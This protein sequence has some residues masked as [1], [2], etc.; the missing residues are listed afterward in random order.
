MV[1]IA[2][3]GADDSGRRLWEAVTACGDVEVL[4]FVDPD[5]RRQGRQLLG[6]NVRPLEWLSRGCCDAVVLPDREAALSASVL[7]SLG[8]TGQ[9]VVCL[10]V[11]VNDDQLARAAADRFPDPLSTLLARPAAPGVRVG[12]FGTGAA[13]VKVWEALAGIDGADAAWFADNDVRRQGVPFLWLE[14]IAPSEIPAR[15]FD[16]VA[17]GSMSRDAIESQL[18]ALGVP[19]PRIL[20]PD[21]TADVDRIREQLAGA[22]SERWLPGARA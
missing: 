8:L 19:Q 22:L 9:R 17:I 5:P 12:V 2:I 11:T 15:S 6:V 21:V 16:V 7:A 1:R 10:P 20:A 18:I 13:G 4:A 14:V 3:L